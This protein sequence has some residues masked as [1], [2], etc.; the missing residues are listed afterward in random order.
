VSADRV[1]GI[2]LVAL[3]LAVIAE[4]RAL[5]LGTLREPGPGFTPVLLAALVAALGAAVAA[6]GGAGTPLARLGWREA[7]H[8]LAILAAC[9]FAALALER[10]GYRLTVAV[11]LLFLLG[12]LERKRPVFAVLFAGALAFG[13]FYLFDTLLRVPLPRGALGL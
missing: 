8:A 1:A 13:T 3:G 4:S 7:P 6:G 9:A 11:V 10:L 5:P 12:A 2:A